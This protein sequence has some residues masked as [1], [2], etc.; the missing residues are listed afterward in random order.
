ML[1]DLV[2]P[3]RTAALVT[4]RRSSPMWWGALERT[5]RPGQRGP[6]SRLLKGF[7]VHLSQVAVRI[8]P[9]TDIGSSGSDPIISPF[10]PSVDVSRPLSLLFLRILF[11]LLAPRS[12]PL[13]SLSHLSPLHFL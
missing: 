1:A 4:M 8:M 6:L 5:F 10:D 7:A 11:H 2:E 13:P 12:P 3:R 9:G